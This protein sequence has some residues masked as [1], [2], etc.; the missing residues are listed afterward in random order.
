MELTGFSR[1]IVF[2]AE[3]YGPNIYGWMSTGFFCKICENGVASL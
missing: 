2:L 3:D 1:K